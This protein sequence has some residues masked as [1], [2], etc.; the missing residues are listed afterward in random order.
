M[1]CDVM[2]RG[3]MWCDV[4]W[5][6]VM[7][8]DVMWCDVMWRGVVWRGVVWCGYG[9][10]EEELNED[11]AEGQQASQQHANAKSHIPRPLRHLHNVIHHLNYIHT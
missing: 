10:D 1:W 9:E 2:W 3:V 11:S 5:R 8:R 6:D 7:W 4:M